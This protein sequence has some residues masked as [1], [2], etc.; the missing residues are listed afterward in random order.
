[1]FPATLRV[2]TYS[3]SRKRFRAEHTG[4]NPTIRSTQRVT[5]RSLRHKCPQPFIVIRLTRGIRKSVAIRSQTDGL[6]KPTEPTI[7]IPAIGSEP[8]GPARRCSRTERPRNSGA[9]FP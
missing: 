2:P 6:A 4:W 5:L 8:A 3:G 7:S 1:M 9:Y